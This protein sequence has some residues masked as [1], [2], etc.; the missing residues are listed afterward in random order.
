MGKYKDEKASKHSFLRK[1]H[2]NYEWLVMPFRLT[3]ALS[4]F[5]RLMNHVLCSLIGQCVV[6]YF[7]DIL[8]ESLYVNLE[9]CIF[10]IIEVIVLGF[11]VSSKGVH[12]DK[13]KVK[14]I[15]NWQNSTNVSD[16]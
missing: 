6:V 1:F 8:D 2:V 11:V 9:K 13:E 5:M 7:D 3:N 12:V 16:V 10:C 14:A 15:Q 4:M